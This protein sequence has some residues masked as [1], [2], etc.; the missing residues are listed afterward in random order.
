M[1]TPDLSPLANHL[2]QSTFF[3]AGAWLLTLAVRRNHAAVRYWIWLAASVK[4]LIPFSVL[5]TIGSQLGSRSAPVVI[6]PQL[7]NLMDEIS[8]PF[9]RSA[10]VSTL[11][12]APP[13][14]SHLP[15]IL[16]G[17]WL[18]GVMLGLIFWLRLLREAR[19]VQRA[20]T[21]L[22]LQLPI[23]VMCSSARLE[24]GVFG[25]RKPVLVLPS[26]ITNRLTP[27]QLE[28]VLAHELCH[29]RRRDNL[30]AAIH[31]VVEV[32]FWFHPLV[33]WIRMQL[34]AERER[35]CDEEVVRLAGDPQVYAEAIL[36]VCKLYIESP[37]VCVSGGTGGDLKRRIEA[38]MSDHAALRLN[39]AKKAALTVAGL[40]ALA[41]PVTVG[42]I[43]A[44]RVW[45][46]SLQLAV[47]LVTAAG[48]KFEV[49][50]IK[51]V[52][53]SAPHPPDSFEL[54]MLMGT[55]Q[56]NGRFSMR[57]VPLNVLIQLAY[58]VQDS[59]ILGGP[60]WTNSDRY[61]VIAK[62]DGNATFEQMR[63]ML[64]SLLA[65]RFKL[66]LR[67]ETRELPVYT[68]AVAKGG[69]KIDAAKEGSCLTPDPSNPPPP[70]NPNHP[71]GPC[72]GVV[73]EVASPAPERRDLILGFGILMPKLVE[74]I[75][76][77]VRR[78][79]IDNTGFAQRFDLHLEFA[80]SGVT[81]NGIGSASSGDPGT[82]APSPDLSGVSIFAALQQLGLRLEST[83]LPV[84][85]LVI[86]HM[87]R[88]SEN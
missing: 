88:P 67:R 47:P 22:D 33:W 8:Q 34:V 27:P 19:A 21:P 62:A 80:P 73:R 29:V 25:I 86:D 28:A 30:T 79:V 60:S 77:D 18:C 44:P 11:T 41:G 42:V 71:L 15:M 72:G 14:P 49:A 20:A 59:R 78:I 24:P 65:D 52:L 32:I 40:A 82:A 68:L 46:Q 36:N 16:L 4:F 75:S 23:P 70:L 55:R 87:E 66:A 13:S 48:P 45:A 5:V 37:L 17:V 50:S 58:N 39:Y 7:T 51:P 9:A 35:A 2:W 26:G 38:I 12:A 69:L 63:P 10:D 84:E 53:G 54:N 57:N 74:I 85:V 1:I 81:G 61:E 43:H 83:R 3:A 31:M 6:Q 64:Q 76:D 56:E